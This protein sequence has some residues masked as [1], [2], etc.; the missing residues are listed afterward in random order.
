LVGFYEKHKK[1]IVRVFLFSF[2]GFTNLE[3]VKKLL[4]FKFKQKIC[5]KNFNLWR[6]FFPRKRRNGDKH[7]T[8]GD[9]KFV[10]ITKS[11]YNSTK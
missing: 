4:G 9:P 11:S 3:L 2:F 6:M 1:V 7:E 10:K 5:C 8:H